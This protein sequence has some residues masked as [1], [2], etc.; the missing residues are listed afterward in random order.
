MRKSQIGCVR[1]FKKNW[2]EIMRGYYERL[3]QSVVGTREERMNE[4]EELR[5]A[6]E[7]EEM[8]EQMRAEGYAR[9]VVETARRVLDEVRRGV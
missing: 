9:L 7:R 3:P 1:N 2:G 8:W 6:A 5:E 4:F